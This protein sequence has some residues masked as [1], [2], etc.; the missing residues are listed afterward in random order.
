MYI[1]KVI[2]RGTDTHTHTH[3]HIF[4]QYSGISS[5]SFGSSYT[6]ALKQ[7]A[8]ARVFHAW[9]EDWEIGIRYKN[10]PV[11]EARL[12]QKY[13]GLVFSD[14]DNN[15]TYSVF[16][17]N[18]EY[19]RGSNNGWYVIAVSAEEGVEDEVFSL[20]LACELIGLTQQASGVQVIFAA[21]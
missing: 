21:N 4:S 18:M 10:D 6:N 13:K 16:E 14:P 8:T 3:S 20:E 7:P 5:Y 2:C 15:I 9:V 1:P 12:L 11:T 19:R 17:E